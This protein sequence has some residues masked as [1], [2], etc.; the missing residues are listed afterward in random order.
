MPE[1]RNG[2]PPT[3]RRGERTVRSFLLRSPLAIFILGSLSLPATALFLRGADFVHM[4]Y[5]TSGQE[6]LWFMLTAL[7]L[8]LLATSLLVVDKDFKGLRSAWPGT[9]RERAVV[10]L[11]TALAG[12]LNALPFVGQY[13][14]QQTWPVSEG[15]LRLVPDF[16]RKMLVL[17]SLFSAVTAL[18]AS[19]MFGVHVQ[20][21][22]LLREPPA[23]GQ[24]PATDSLEEDVLRYQRLQAQLKRFL[25]FSAAIIATSLLSIG[26]FRGMVNA[27]APSRP[28]AMPAALVMTFG[29]YFTGLLAS[30]YLPA[31]RTLTLVGQVLAERLGGPSLRAC[32]SWRDFSQEQQALHAWLGLQTT[33]LQDLQ[34]AVT[35]LAPL[36]ASL[37]T[38]VLGLGG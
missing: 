36:L 32:T 15:V 20:L 34:Q 3:G 21:L 17:G 37:S 29:L 18:H 13:L 38:L 9:R 31:R 25:S 7:H 4:A 2:P 16:P 19:G 26:A 10:V 22:G 35:V 12:T 1:S 27:T 23:H 8:A 33:A 11:C 6:R 28:E 30:I 24:A 5:W 14:F